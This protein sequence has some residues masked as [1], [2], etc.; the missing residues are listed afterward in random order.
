VSVRNYLNNNERVVTTKKLIA[1]GLYDELYNVYCTS[2]EKYIK[3][4]QKCSASIQGDDKMLNPYSAIVCFKPPLSKFLKEHKVLFSEEYSIYINYSVIKKSH[5]FNM[6][7]YSIDSASFVPRIVSFDVYLR[8]LDFCVISHIIH[9]AQN[10]G[11]N[12]S[13]EDAYISLKSRF[14]FYAKNH[15]FTRDNNQINCL[16]LQNVIK[17]IRLCFGF[18]HCYRNGHDIKEVKAKVL[19]SNSKGNVSVENIYVHG[20]LHCDKYFVEDNIF[21]I[22][23][24]RHHNLLV[25]VFSEDGK[26]YYNEHKGYYLISEGSERSLLNILGYNTKISEDTRRTRLATILSCKQMKKYEISKHLN[27]LLWR[28]KNNP[29]HYHSIPIWEADL[30]FLADFDLDTH[31]EIYGE[32]VASAKRLGL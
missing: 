13:V 10:C 4:L 24:E 17:E 23:Q 2:S 9:V 12:I 27:Y 32:I 22:Y 14:D 5:L 15:I 31:D 3:Y 26:I 11:R 21:Q 19:C 20:C 30:G 6:F 18:V 8:E 7:T 16:D 25:K 29:R 1:L 28:N